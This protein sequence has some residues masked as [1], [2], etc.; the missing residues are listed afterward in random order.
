MAAQMLPRPAAFT[1][2]GALLRNRWLEDAG[3]DTVCLLMF[4]WDLEEALYVRYGAQ[5]GSE[6]YA[7]GDSLYRCPIVMH[8]LL[9]GEVSEECLTRYGS[10]DEESDCR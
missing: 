10:Q 2:S 4:N 3:L 7:L 6:W 5:A 9:S 1:A 8:R